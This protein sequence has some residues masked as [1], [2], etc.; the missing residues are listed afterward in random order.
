MPCYDYW[1]ENCGAVSAWRPMSESAEPLPCPTCSTMASRRIAASQI[2]TLSPQTRMA[3]ARNERSADAPRVVTRTP[4]ADVRP[5][6]RRHP[7]L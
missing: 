5:G 2:A 6:T 4:R 1:C 3:W 7:G